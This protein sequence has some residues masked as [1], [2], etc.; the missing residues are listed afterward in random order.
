MNK[1]KFARVISDVFIPITFSA[2]ISFYFS[3][4][5]SDIDKSFSEIFLL[6]FLST[7]LIPL[8]Y[9]LHKRR[10]GE[11]I[12]RDAVIKEQRNDVY[13]FSVFVFS[14]AYVISVVGHFPILVQIYLFNFT[15][16]TI[17]VYFINKK[18]KISIHSMSASG[19]AT[20]LIF[21]NPALSVLFFVLTIIIMWSRVT[22]KVHTL[23]EVIYGMVYGICVTLFV[24]IL[25]LS[26][27]SL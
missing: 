24:T 17:G 15:I 22:L 7:V 13:L 12:N 11:I 2:F 3:L 4:I 10:K 19:T 20:I 5:F 21:V 14:V 27:A 6:T 18:F 8:I 1:Q 9:F 25:V 16:S 23:K 26:Y